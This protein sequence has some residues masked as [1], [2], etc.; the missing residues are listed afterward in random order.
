MF[1]ESDTSFS[2][3]SAGRARTSGGPR[4]AQAFFSATFPA[5]PPVSSPE[6]PSFAS[7]SSSESDPD[8]PSSSSS[9]PDLSSDEL[10]LSICPVRL[11]AVCSSS[12]S[13]CSAS[14]SSCESWFRS[15]PIFATYLRRYWRSCAAVLSVAFLTSTTLATLATLGTTGAVLSEVCAA[16]VSAVVSGRD[17]AVTGLGFESPEKGSSSLAPS[18]PVGAAFLSISSNVFSR[19]LAS[20]LSSLFI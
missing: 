17:D 1:F 11:S 3:E 14:F 8:F 20:S 6:E 9:D 13:S 18:S 15:F 4:R 19:G 10:F 5:P 16:L 7:D 12:R 2:P